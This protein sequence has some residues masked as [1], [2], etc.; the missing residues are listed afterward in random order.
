MARD[1]PTTFVALPSRPH[2]PIIT[3]ANLADKHAS[4]SEGKRASR[5]EEKE[6]P[7]KARERSFSPASDDESSKASYHG[8][9]NNDEGHTYGLPA[10]HSSKSIPMQVLVTGASTIEEQIANLMGAVEKLTRTVEEKDMQIAE[11]YSMLENQEE[12]KREKEGENSKND[13][14]DDDGSLGSISFQQLQDII[15]NSI[16]AQ[17]GESLSF[18]SGASIVDLGN[19]E[20]LLISTL[21]LAKNNV[22]NP[23]SIGQ[24][25]YQKTIEGVVTQYKDDGADEFRCVHCDAWFWLDEANQR[26]SAT[27]PI[28]YI[29]C[30]QKRQVELPKLTQTPNLLEQLLNPNNGRQNLIFRDNIRVYNSIFAF[31]SMG[32]KIDKDVNNGSGPYIFK[33]C[34]QV[35]H[36]MGSRLPSDDEHPK[37]AQLYVYDTRNEIRNRIKAVGSDDIG[38][39]KL[40][41][42]Q[43]LMHMFDE[44][45][46]LV[47]LYRTVRDKFEN[48]SLPS[49]NITMMGRQPN[50]NKQYEE[51]IR[52]E[53]GGSRL[54]WQSRLQRNCHDRLSADP[55]HRFCFVYGTNLPDVRA[56]D[57]SES[58]HQ[59]RF[60]DLTEQDQQNASFFRSKNSLE[61]LDEFKEKQDRLSLRVLEVE[62]WMGAQAPK[63]LTLDPIGASANEGTS[64]YIPP[65]EK[66]KQDEVK[67][68]KQSK[69]RRRQDEMKHEP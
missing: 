63:N 30:V 19:R 42:V 57:E 51:P 53:I 27:G 12:E 56:V 14:K 50:D 58:G 41:I 24:A 38:K 3:L 59:Q 64:K 2:E 6:T 48:S 66:V 13:G 1:Q 21:P 32:G 8:S 22:Q 15:T 9:L 60:A 34:G 45:N 35:H 55:R 28:I 62:D 67:L 46:E 5:S 61:K 26:T 10:D 18:V 39:I 65:N 4:R 54:V 31:T 47:K 11:L 68:V 17:Y 33:I 44:I 23:I 16:R 49:Y 29:G 7:N 69:A 40:E 37:Y 52:D 43:S 20:L 25:S 36:L